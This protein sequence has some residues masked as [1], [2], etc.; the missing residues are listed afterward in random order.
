MNIL[1]DDDYKLILEN[2]GV[3]LEELKA[4]TDEFIKT[5]TKDLSNNSDELS[6]DEQKVFK[7]FNMSPLSEK[8]INESVKKN[9]LSFAEMYACFW[10]IG[11]VAEFLG[12]SEKDV[13]KKAESKKLYCIKTTYG[14]KFPSWQF[15]LESAST[16]PGFEEVAPLIP[17]DAHPLS[18]H[19]FFTNVHCDLEVEEKSKELQLTPI[20][21][22][23]R[24]FSTK[25]I[26]RILQFFHCT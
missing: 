4:A 11:N 17:D 6:A 8:E 22:L 19:L 10:N 26:I 2:S 13:L 12:I 25:P 21:W 15:S 23:S 24:G 3:S 14:P 1:S 18:V 16:L 20:E 7:S 5:I 9:A